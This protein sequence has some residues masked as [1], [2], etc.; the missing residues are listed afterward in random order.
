ML[1]TYVINIYRFV[2]SLEMENVYLL[3]VSKIRA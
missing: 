3:Y 2:S 1:L